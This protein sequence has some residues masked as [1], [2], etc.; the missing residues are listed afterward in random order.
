MQ[1]KLTC[2]KEIYDG[3]SAIEETGGF[4]LFFLDLCNAHAQCYSNI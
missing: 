2:A 4:V 1:S 3:S